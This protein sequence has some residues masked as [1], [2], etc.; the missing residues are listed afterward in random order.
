MQV[1]GDMYKQ[2]TIFML[3]GLIYWLVDSLDWHTDDF[4]FTVL[5]TLEQSLFIQ[6]FE[7]IVESINFKIVP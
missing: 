1:W 4:F 2:R 5:N 7:K 3:A 6:V